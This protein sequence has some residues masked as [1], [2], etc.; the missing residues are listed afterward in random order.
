MVCCAVLATASSRDYR[1]AG[2]KQI[3]DGGIILMHPESKSGCLENII[4]ILTKQG[5][6]FVTVSEL[7]QE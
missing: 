4:D 5:Y 6:K 2:C 7:I 1:S 3:D